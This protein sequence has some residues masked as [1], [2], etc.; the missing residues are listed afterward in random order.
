MHSPTKFSER[1]SSETSE[2]SPDVTICP[3][4]HFKD[5]SFWK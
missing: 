4:R 5:T 1:A 2:V 3:L